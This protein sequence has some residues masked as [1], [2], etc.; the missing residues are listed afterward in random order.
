M[1]I[2]IVAP[3]PVPFTIGGAEKLWWGLQNFI[4][5]YSSHQCELFKI[6]TKEDS[7]WNLIDS[8]HSFYQLDLSDFDMVLTTK[9]PA[10]MVQHDN[11]VLYLQHHLRGLFDTYHFS[12]E[13]LIIPSHLLVGDVQKVF[14]L[15]NEV[16]IS[17]ER[18]IEV[19]TLLTHLKFEKEKYDEQTFKF[20]GPFIRR[21]IHF[22]DRFALNPSR[23][24]KYYAISNTVINRENYF[25]VGV[26][27]TPLYHPSRIEDFECKGYEYV[28]TASRLDSPKRIDL[29]IKAMRFVKDDIKLKI[30]GT[31]PNEQKLKK[32]AENDKRIELLG[33]KS[34]EELVDLYSKALVVIYIPF[35]EDYGLITIEAMKS[36]KPIIT[37]TDSGGTLEFVKNGENGFIIEPN[38]EDIGSKI[39]Y[40]VKNKDVAVEMGNSAF[41]A[42]KEVSW[43]NVVSTIIN[44]KIN[45]QKTRKKI[46]VLSTYSC[47]PP[48][49]G[50]Q[51]RIYHIYS[52]LA[53]KYDVTIC[54][55]IESNKSYQNLILKNG[56]KQ[57][58]VPQSHS[59]AT[60]QWELERKVGINLYDVAMI[61]NV[62]L[63]Q[64]YIIKVKE[65]L[66]ESDIV[67]FSHPYLYSLKSYAKED[68]IIIYEAHNMEYLLKKDYVKDKQLLEKLFTR[69]NNACNET[70]LTLVTSDEDKE[71]II[72]YYNSNPDK[73]FVIPNGVDTTSIQD[74]PLQ[75]KNDQKKTTGLLNFPIILFVGSWHPPNLEAL[76]FI[77]E[78][79]IPKRED[80]IFMVIGSVCDYY[81]HEIG[82][83]PGNMLAFGTVTEEEKYELYKL[84]D[85]AINPML[86]GSGTNLKMLDYMSAG[87]PVISTSVGAR[88]IGIESSRQ[89]IICPTEQF[90]D[91]IIELYNNKT[92]QNTLKQ[93]G[94]DL[95]ERKYSWKTIA[96]NFDEILRRHV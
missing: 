70:H 38:P 49:G 77:V 47:Y 56:L 81:R 85:I 74:I 44:E 78:S 43:K 28:F 8:Y 1:K 17:K 51:H 46:L 87:I 68:Q 41:E 37:S 66:N 27:V 35:D 26:R 80:C 33:Y 18:L 83:L 60:I 42:V 94:R 40:L 58:C 91:R 13:S 2:A 32:L 55:I 67:I 45:S 79:L 4:N 20:P 69:E 12:N 95:V 64:E 71:N 48:Q 3:S 92:L 21:I 19:F 9:Y 65:Y 34:E 50:G 82:E 93:N 57:V 61:D 22:F 10:W 52:L 39:N 96:D 6:I 72:R 86:S 89:A 24:R 54:S 15:I 88:G 7:F 63:S 5:N 53:K 75:M 23:I 16:E 59:H 11:H 31:G 90:S 30:A 14:N 76:Q 62:E 84:A 36:R 25:P 29:M 73:I